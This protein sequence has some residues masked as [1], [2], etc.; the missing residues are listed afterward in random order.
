MVS[1]CLAA[2]RFLHVR[3]TSI[4]DLHTHCGLDNACKQPDTDIRIATT[5][6]YV[7]CTNVTAQLGQQQRQHNDGDGDGDGDENDKR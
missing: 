2:P 7:H 1:G 6:M 5:R 4:D 3:D